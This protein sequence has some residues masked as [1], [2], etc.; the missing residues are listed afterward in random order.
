MSNHITRKSFLKKA[1]LLTLGFSGLSNYLLSQTVNAI[2][3]KSIELIKDPNGI[4]DLP[5]GFEYKVIST[6]GKKMSDGLQVPDHAD[7]MGCFKGGKNQIKLIRNHEIGRFEQYEFKHEYKKS[8]FG[9]VDNIFDFYSKNNVYDSCVDDTVCFGGTTT[10]VY[11]TKKEVVEDEYLSLAGTLINCSGGIT[12]WNTWITCEET[13]AT[14]NKFLLKDHGYN[15]EVDPA[16]KENI[17]TPL[18]AMGRFRHEAVAFDPKSGSVYQT[19]DR[20]DGMIY[21]FL[22][23]NKKNL[24][25]GGKLQA[26]AFIKDIQDTRNW[27]NQIIEKNYPYEVK[28]IDIENVESPNDDL[29]HQGYEKGC[30]RF[31]RPEGLWEYNGEIFFTCTSG[32]KKEL[33]QIWK[34]IPSPNEGMPDEKNNPGTVELFFESEDSKDLDMC[35]NIT[36]SPWGDI[37]ICEDGRGVDYLVGIKPNGVSYK[38]AKN[39]FNKSEF[40]GACFSPD[41]KILFVNIYKPTK[42][43][44][45]KPKEGNTWESFSI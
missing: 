30:A 20:H 44:A 13:A 10:I 35:D 27:E 6:F 25:K 16:I 18:K 42:T 38:L 23:N 15:F 40:A 17:P 43:I 45:I 7:G 31:A 39:A 36:V 11:N 4:I 22:P 8:A 21:R 12:P 34:Y 14:K 41:G 32:G 37:I 2:N 1:S 24:K 29:R 28:W 9:K 26:L 3:N 19:E 5:K 33:G